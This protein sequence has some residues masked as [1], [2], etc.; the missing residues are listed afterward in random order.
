MHELGI[1][2]GIVEIAE[3]H[4]RRQGCAKVLS[5]K[6]A[7]GDLAGVMAEA[8]AFCFPSCAR[9]T[10]LDGA[11]LEIERIGGKGRCAVCGTGFPL[12]VYTLACPACAA[13]G[14]EVLQGRELRVVEL[15]VE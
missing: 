3:T 10:L 11:R 8:V 2:R 15:E 6:V 13:L 7:I 12:D 5:V 9:G 14:P 1:T 4:A